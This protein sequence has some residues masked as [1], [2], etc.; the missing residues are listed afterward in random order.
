MSDTQVSAA[1]TAAV[2]LPA[3]VVSAMADSDKA[4]ADKLRQVT[5]SLKQWKLPVK[6]ATVAGVPASTFRVCGMNM[7]LAQIGKHV[8]LAT[9]QQS[10]ASANATIRGEDGLIP[11]AQSATYKE[12][13][14]GLGNS[15][16]LTLYVNLA[17]IQGLGYLAE[18][19]GLHPTYGILTGYLQGMQAM[20]VGL[21]FDGEAAS[22]TMFCRSK[23]GSGATIGPALAA[24]GAAVVFPMIAKTRE[25][26]RES[27]C[28][29]NLKQLA[30]SAL[31]YA[32]DHGGKLPT[33]A[34]WQSQFA[35]Y[36]ATGARC[37]DGGI[38]AFNKNLSGLNLY[39]IKNQEDVIMFFEA[40]PGLANASGSRADAILP[41]HGSGFFAFAD[42]HVGS[43]SEVPAQKYW[44]PKY[45]R[46]QAGEDA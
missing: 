3:G 19:L 8:L 32:N 31:L 2:P 36:I 40:E 22:L 14:A 30:V 12:T 33:S 35:P 39:K 20:G 10:F 42:S 1:I 34:H 27:V 25:S 46:A 38:Y 6:P 13:M 21:G 41:H 18:G 9:D 45:R 37:P 17:P 26:A 5:D 7:Y 23:P 16:L 15:N 28:R 44:V 29:S 43:L 4:A 11:L 24:I